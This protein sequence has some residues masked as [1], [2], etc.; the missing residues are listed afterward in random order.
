MSIAMKVY[1]FFDEYLTFIIPQ[2]IEDNPSWDGVTITPI[3][4]EVPEL[5]TNTV[6]DNEEYCITPIH[7]ETKSNGQTITRKF[8]DLL[9]D[10]LI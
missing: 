3:H 8:G 7:E 10:E 4:A 9:A 2:K 1:N 6:E 5:F